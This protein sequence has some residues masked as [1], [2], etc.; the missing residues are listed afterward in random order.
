MEGRDERIT[1]VS[2]ANEFWAD[3]VTNTITATL[4]AGGEKLKA[5]TQ[6]AAAGSATDSAASPAASAGAISGDQAVV[7][8]SKSTGGVGAHVMQSFSS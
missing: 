2:A 4:L 3:N 1:A 7:T 6:S 5:T 8:A